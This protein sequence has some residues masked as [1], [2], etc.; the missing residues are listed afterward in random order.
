MR[1]E[2][3]EGESIP[4]APVTVT[5]P[6]AP[7]PAPTGVTVADDFYDCVVLDWTGPTATP[8]HGY[9]LERAPDGLTRQSGRKLQ[10]DTEEAVPH[11]DD[12]D[13]VQAA[14]TYQYRIQ[15]LN[16]GVKGAW[17]APMPGT[18]RAALALPGA[19][20]ELAVAPTADSR[21]QLTWAAPRDHG[22]RPLTGYCVE[23]SPDET[24]RVWTAVVADTDSP[25]RTWEERDLESDTVYHYR[26]RALTSHGMGAASNEAEG[27]T[28]AQLRLETEIR[29]PLTAHAEPQ[30]AAAVT[31]TF[32][33]H[34]ENRRQDV[35]AQLPGEDGWWR[36][37]LFGQATQ[38]PFW[39]PATAVTVTGTT[40]ALPQAPGIP[41]HLTAVPANGAVDLTWSAPLT[42]G[43]VTGYRLW[44]RR[45][46][47][48][49]ATLGSDLGATVLTHTD[50]TA[51]AGTDYEYRLQAV[52]AES[53]GP[54]TD[55]ISTAAPNAP[56]DL[57]ATPTAETQLTLS[58]SAPTTGSPVRGYRIERAVAADPRVWADAVADTGTLEVSWNDS[59]LTAATVYHYRVTARSAVGLGAV[60][61]E[62]EARTRPQLTL[63]TAATYPV[64]AR[65][66]PAAEAPVTHSWAVHDATVTLD[67]AGQV[68]GSNG[69]WRVL[70]FSES[71]SGPYW[72]P[73]S[74][75][76]V[77]GAPTDVPVAPGLP[78]DLAHTTTHETVTLTWTAPTTGGTVTGYRLWRQTGADA[79]TVLF[80]GLVASAL[81][82]TDFFLSAETTYQYRLQALSAAGAG[83][84]AA[85]ESATT[86]AD[87]VPG[88]PTALTAAPGND[89]QLALTWTAPLDT[90]TH[91]IAGY[92]IERSA[93]V[94]PRNW[95]EA[96]ANTGTPQTVWHDS[97]LAADTAFHYRVSA[98][99]GAGE[100]DPSHEAEG[101]TRPQ[102]ALLAAVTYPVQ[103]YAWPATEA[104]VT[105]T[106]DT[107]DAAVLLDVVGQVAG[108]DGWWRGLR[109]GASASGPYWVPAAAVTV[110]G[111]TM[112]V[113]AAPGLPTALAAMATHESVTL[114][115]TAPT[116]GGT[117]SGYRLWR[118][119][120][121]GP[122]AVVGNDLAAATLT[123]TD[124]GL[125]SASAYQYRLQALSAAGAG[126]RTA[127]ESI[128]TAGPVK[129]TELT[130]A[131]GDNSQMELSWTAPT[132]GGPVTGY[133]IERAADAASRVWAEAVANTGHTD[134]TWQDSGLTA[135]T[136]YHYRVSAHRTAGV[137]DP[138]PEATGR[139]RPQLAL[140]ASA[141]YPLT[142]HAWPQTAAPVTHTWA[143][144]DATVLLDVA[145]QGPGGGSWYRALRFED[146]ASG[147]YWLPATAV[148]VTGSPT[149][150][151]QAPGL[152]GAFTLPT[153]THDT[154][155]LSWSAP[156]TGGAVM[157][158]RL[159]RQTGTGEMT[160]LGADLAADVLAHT[161]SSLTAETAYQYR[162]QARSAA[163]PGPRT[164]AV[165]ITTAESPRVPGMPTELTAAPG[166]DSQMEL[167]W[168]GPADPGVPTLTGYRIERSADVDPRVWTEVVPDSGTPEPTWADS[169]LAARTVYHY[170]VTGRNA[171]GLGTASGEGTGTTRPLL[172]LNATA[173]YPLT[174]HAWPATEAP[175]THTWAAHDATVR[176]DLVAQGG[177]GWWRAVRFGAGSS[178]PYW[179]PAAAVT[180]TGASTDLPQGPGVPEELAAP[181]ATHDSVS[182]SWSAPTTGGAVTGYRLWRQ[183]GAEAFVVLGA[184]LAADVLTHT[185]PGL[186]L[187]TTYQYRLQA[188]SAAGAGPRTAAVSGTTG[189]LLPLVQDYGP[190]THTLTIPAGY[191]TLYVQLCG[192]GGGGGGGDTDD[193]LVGANGGNGGITYHSTSLARSDQWQ[194]VVGRGG[195]GADT[196]EDPE[197]GYPGEGTYLLRYNLTVA[198]ATW[199]QG[200]AAGAGGLS[201]PDGSIRG[202]TAGWPASWPGNLGAAGGG[203]RGRIGNSER[204]GADGGDGRA[205][206]LLIPALM[207]PTG[208]PPLVQNYGS[209][210]HTLTIPT[211]YN[212][213]YVLL[214]GGGGGGAGGA[215]E[216]INGG[217]GGDGACT[218]HTALLGSHTWSL[219]VGDGG[220]GGDYEENYGLAGYP[221]RS[222]QLRRDGISVATARGGEGGYPRNDD[223]SDGTTTSSSEGWPLAWPGLETPPRG[224][225]GGYGNREED[226]Q[227]GTAG[228][229]QVL[230]IAAPTAP[231]VPTGLTAEPAADSQLE[232]RWVAAAAGSAATG[233]R[234][235]RSADVDPRVWTEVLADSGTPVT[236]WA[237]SG[238]AAATVYHYQVTGRN[239]E[240]LGTPSAESMGTT[241]PQAALLDTAPYPLTAHQWPAPTAPA[242]HSWAAH[243][244]SL[245]LD[246][247]GQ[248]AGG[249]GWYRALRF[250]ESASGPYWLPAAAV[251][252]T[253]TT[254]AVPAAPGQATAL[255]AVATHETV[256]LR[257]MAPTGG[258]PVT[259]YRLWRQTGTAALAGVGTDLA[260]ESLSHTDR[261]LTAQTAYQYRL[262]AR[263]AAGYGLRTAAVSVT[264]AQTPRVPDMPAGLTA[265]PGTDS[266]MQLTWTTPAD[267]G[268]Q[269]LTGYRI[270]RSADVDP[271]VWADVLADSGNTEVTWRDRGLEADTVYHYQVRARNSVGLSGPAAA[272]QGR[273]RPQLVL[274]ADATY[275]LT[276]RQWPETAAPVTH[277]WA[278]HDAT[279]Q[280]D[281]VG[282]GS[283]TE[284]WYRALRFG[285]SASGP[286]WL[287]AGAVTI[288]GAT[289]EV[290]LTP[291]LPTAL[292]ATATHESVSLSWTAPTAG[293]TVTGYRLWRQ[294][295]TGTLAVHG[296]ELAGDALTHMDTGL[297]AESAYQ[298]R[299]QALA[300]AGAGTRTAGVS[301]TTLASP[302][303]AAPTDLTATPSLESQ[304]E[305]RWV[306]PAAG[307]AAT[308][309]RIERA[310][311]AEPLV[312]SEVEADTGTPDVTWADSGLGAD[313]VYHYRVTGRNAA[314]LGDSTTAQGRTRPQL[315]LAVTAPYPLAA[316]AWPVATAPVTHS[317][318]A[319][320]ATVQL[321]VAGQV[322]G[323]DGWWRGVRFG[324]SA[325]GPYWIPAAAV[326]I[327][328][329]TTAVPQA[330][331]TPTALAAT[332]THETVTLRWTAPTTGGPVTGYRLWRQT[333]TAAFAVVGADLAAESLSHT[334]RG[335]TAQTAYQYRLQARSAAGYGL[336]TAAVSITTAQ[337]PR[338]PGVPTALAAAPGADS[339]MALSWRAP[340]DAGTQPLTGYRIERA[341]AADPL[342]W[343]EVLA[344]TGR[345]DLTWADSGLAADTVYHYR[346]AGR[347]AVGV[348]DPAAAA[349]GRTRPQLVL[350]ATATY[351][352]TAHAW[353]VAAAPVTHTWAAHDATVQ[354]DI[355][356]QVAGT[357]GWWRALRFGASASGPYWLPAGAVTVTGSTTT[358]PAAPGLPTALAA[359]ASH[360][361]VSL[362]WSAP[363]TGGTV[364]GYRLWRQTGMGSLAVLGA[365]LAADALTHTDSGLRAATAYQYRLQALSAAG[366]GARTAGV[367]ITTLAAP[368][369]PGAPT[370]LSA[371]PTPDSQLELSWTAPTTGSAA[372]SYQIERA[373]EADPLVWTVVTT[374]TGSTDVTWAD[375]GLTAAT[376]YHYRVSARNAVGLGEPA[377][378]AEGRTRPQLA[379]LA[380]APYPLTAQQWP[381]ATAPVTHTWAAHDATVTLDLVAQGPGG[382]G[383]WRALRF[384]QSASGPYWVAASAVTVTGS[385]TDLP[386]A[387]GTP[388]DLLATAT[389]ASVTLSWTA[390]SGGGAVTGY[391]LWRQSGEGAF[392]VL[393]AALAAV[394]THT[395]TAVTASTAY[396][397]R[398][399]ALAAPAG[400]GPRTA[401][402]G[403][404]TAE[405]PRV[406]G[407]PTALTAAPG[408]DSQMAL[409]WSAP[410]DVGTQPLTGYRLERAADVEPRVWSE[411]VA[412]TGTTDVTGADSGLTAATT[413]HYR[414]SARNAVGVGAASVTA[415]GTTRPQLALLATAPYPLTA[416]QWP[417]AAAPVTHT[418]SAHAASEVL[419]VAAQGAGGGGWWQALR[420][421]AS[422]SGPYWIPASAVTVT[423]STTDLRQAPGPPGDLTARATHDTVTLTWTAP[424]TGGT[425]TGY[426]LWRQSG[427]GAF[428]VLGADRAAAAV[429]AA[430]TDVTASTAYQ[431]R[432]QALGAV[433]AGVRSAPVSVTVAALPP[434][435]PT[436]PTPH[437]AQTGAQALQL[438]W[439]A[440]AGARGYDLELFQSWYDAATA[441]YQSAWVLLTAAGPT[442]IETGATSSVDVTFT[443]TDSLATLQGLPATYS[444]WRLRVR[445]TNAGGVS[446][447][448]DGC[449]QRVGTTAF[450]PLAPTGL[451][452]QRTAA[453]TVALDW[454]AV[455]GAGSYLVYYHFPADSQGSAGWDLLPWRG[456]AASG[457]GTTATVTG[458]PLTAAAWSLRV[459]A[460]TAAGSQSVPSLPVAVANPD[461]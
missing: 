326:T 423:G 121:T 361:R 170:Q 311:A 74:A 429:T 336:R 341:A 349:E 392:T 89:S 86:D 446:A 124:P 32:H 277:T 270:E 31:A 2:N 101:R 396:Q 235:E 302:F 383:W 245:G 198:R 185:D 70:R 49:F 192:G 247:T 371:R 179:L 295:G 331:G 460:R 323:T 358:V 15:A 56:A 220:D 135:D 242:T 296:E 354:L 228:R 410:A 317:W 436:P 116:T 176:L 282:Q 156:T 273:T 43:A 390:P 271:R 134:T 106:W 449:S 236:V 202:S 400:A 161:D 264:T 387:P 372:T 292:T 230:L 76:T 125:T 41:Q 19:P 339:Q 33:M 418:W 1:A 363:S 60:S 284:G 35:V 132:S 92:H 199:G 402:V 216:F 181:R 197:K 54:W 306:A 412:D 99:S 384:G 421:G 143:A 408:T 61:A 397:Y 126:P 207:A 444:Y 366:A 448:S 328:G 294:T 254:T 29:Y 388:T 206:V 183:T 290:P 153:A 8:V 406:P 151:A 25:A 238:L 457:V 443:R 75:A 144:H 274:N 257:W 259:A 229:A 108:T 321:D 337:T 23:R 248:G 59:G 217:D 18:T 353:P 57:A 171:A 425:V 95:Q 168:G 172:V 360:D 367:S 100:G 154:V 145:A 453:G 191:D 324:A 401:A 312:W 313:T 330:P 102:L 258:G 368:V 333:G 81:S 173:A 152:P 391:R 244:A 356:G 394:L 3:D 137:G 114:S 272:M 416:H 84:R 129:P 378:A 226:G 357:A 298:Y 109:F 344:A 107:Y 204:D 80:D 69:W 94:D 211:G 299:L 53:P 456:V 165:G 332:A 432:L 55:A 77:T 237:D 377:A 91:A 13:G 293:G 5:T 373:V 110:T 82:Y 26:V 160:V 208:P 225:R 411:V 10:P 136:V 431:Y 159:W 131:P 227:D 215:Y 340:A 334:D 435:P 458:L 190:G 355:G 21:L 122:L 219:V 369:V 243:D 73:A 288:T 177:G 36:L 47:A 87:R 310:V 451:T 351:P 195:E 46:P 433:G 389:H 71:A 189:G 162:V 222:S 352:L 327:T 117:V 440:V 450:R 17:S 424:A 88:V 234:I 362:S 304:L 175:E 147:P 182:L 58:W 24:P 4:S 27:Q 319:H 48:A 119:R 214:C 158:Y 239:A 150:L 218:F 178:G 113:P 20:A 379:L 223:G 405:T 374:D 267:A 163:G 399:Q 212:T 266:Q 200:G 260:A 261:G 105:Q 338:V 7:P 305:L 419:D 184:D 393:G 112:E 375:S 203:D 72:L 249:G 209:G 96:M 434:A 9:A 345:T 426:R 285:A 139:T 335:L 42:G 263:S 120:G 186:A 255:A 413:Y 315:A 231:D 167:A 16:S 97:D 308:G 307:D 325:S 455:A 300:A 347:N 439:A 289:T 348:G 65:A 123:H 269:P 194:L 415:A 442:T 441:S 438:R 320:D 52:S 140:Q 233:Y 130:A 381:A 420:F 252:V 322:A 364:S 28:R 142:A 286:Y 251:T 318:A 128:T 380:T 309:Y 40:T 437:C 329:S 365:D 417:A 205:R 385:T 138:S 11:W 250:G 166:A 221:G 403:L 422:A 428:T 146:S 395:D 454:E 241:R 268:T 133:Y 343:T 141:S 210:T 303:P 279:V 127:A 103:A 148:T 398:L 63:K 193:F 430:D 275:P 346:V 253:G 79:W 280:L 90:G 283:G 350:Q 386:Q 68:S 62:V 78:T 37:L 155:T 262:Q 287:S 51:V 14:T 157:G 316:R 246:I 459:E 359:T 224:G 6:P 64:P 240:G 452:G 291:G 66:W 174:A 314:G 93:D 414:V 85:A 196:E 213:L 67:V 276:A 445:A 22:G 256:T 376:T 39:L 12:A 201:T 45:G 265:A 149:D 370:A 169:G 232:L 407:L 98:L 180:V 50:A 278:A 281:I 447:W 427:E 188:V 382:G 409:H 461:A 187:S 297:A 404:T 30:A 34:E 118:Q 164:A 44:R 111:A 115:W 342:V 104:P 301:I 38:G 83:V